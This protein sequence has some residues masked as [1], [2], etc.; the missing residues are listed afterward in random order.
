MKKPEIMDALRERNIPFKNI[1]KKAVL[2]LRLKESLDL[3]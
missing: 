1:E 3:A 2:L